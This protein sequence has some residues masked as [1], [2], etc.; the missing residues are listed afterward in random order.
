M[1]RFIQ[2]LTVTV[3]GCSTVCVDAAGLVEV[4]LELVLAADVSQSMDSTELKIQRDGYSSALS[5]P[6]FIRAVQAGMLGR[7]AVTYVEWAGAERQNVVVNWQ[8]I[9]SIQSARDFAL[10]VNASARDPARGTSISGALNFGLRMIESN[11]FEGLR[12]VID[13]SGDGP[14]NDGR[15]VL[16]ARADAAADGVVVN[17]LPIIVPGAGVFGNLDDYYADCVITGPGAFSLPAYGIEAFALAIRRKHSDVLSSFFACFL[18]IL[19]AY[20]PLLMSSLD[21][22]KAGSFPPS[23]VWLANIFFALWGLWLLRRVL[24]Y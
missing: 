22:A 2:F 17:G 7:I 4:D 12:K 18:P 10:Q 1:S 19:A 15:Y 3:L 11:D 14:N 5:D 9:D 6:S 24:R 21:R 13:I 20:Y 8:V 16:L 23:S